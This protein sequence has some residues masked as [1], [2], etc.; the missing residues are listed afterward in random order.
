MIVE[1]CVSITLI[2]IHL[3]N[4]R[5]TSDHVGNSVNSAI[6]STFTLTRVSVCRGAP[7]EDSTLE[8]AEGIQTKEAVEAVEAGWLNGLRGWQ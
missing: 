5:P 8:A 2:S 7:C 6:T 4:Q 1:K 3:H